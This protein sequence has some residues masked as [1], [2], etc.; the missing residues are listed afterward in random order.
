MLPES[1]ASSACGP[2]SPVH[3]IAGLK[4]VACSSACDSLCMNWN[5]SVVR[6]T[7]E[8]QPYEPMGPAGWFV[9]DELDDPDEWPADPGAPPSGVLRQKLLG[10][11]P[12]QYPISV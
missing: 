12:T 8:S 2:E 11:H 4:P 10:K 7:G 5:V 1:E 3:R 9:D 6:R